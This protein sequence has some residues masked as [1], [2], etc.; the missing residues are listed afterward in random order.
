MSTVQNIVHVRR[1]RTAR[2]V[3]QKELAARVGISRQSLVAVEAGRQSPSTTVALGLARALGCRVE[4]LFELGHAADMAV[5]LAQRGL[6]AG[7]VAVGQVGERWVAHGVS[8]AQYRGADA[9]IVSAEGL[10]GVARPRVGEASLR[11]NV[12]I[13]G[14]APVL[15]TLAGHVG[16][17]S[18][19]R[20]IPSGSGRALELLSEGLVHVAGVHYREGNAQAVRARFP[21]QRM[22]LV[23]LVSWRQ[24]L[25]MGPNNPHQLAPGDLARAGLRV[26]RRELGAGARSLMQETLRAGGVDVEPA[27]PLCRGHLDVARAV[28]TGAADVGVTI[29]AAAAAFGLEFHPLSEERFDLCMPMSSTQLVPLR[30]ALDAL[31]SR[32]FRAEAEAFGGYG[33]EVTGHAVEVGRG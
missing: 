23:N 26:A 29:E 5:T 6:P 24:G 13:S 8:P 9:V 20:W 10:R 32:A 3:S 27:G 16:E 25:V 4:D 15:A 14:C 17:E 28:A 19:V 31:D 33:V 21:G 30:R 1:I 11:R 18:D 7:R 12:L 2:G 22:L